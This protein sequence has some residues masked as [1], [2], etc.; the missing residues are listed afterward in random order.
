[1]I[2][3]YNTYRY[4]KKEWIRYF[5]QGAGFGAFI[6]YLFYSN[7]MGVFLLT[8]YGLI[9]LHV[10]KKKIIEKR[11]WRLNMEFRDGLASLSAALNAGYSIENAFG[12]AVEDLKLMYPADSMIVL[13]FERIVNELYMNQTV[14]AVLK[15]FADRSGLEDIADFA[16]VFETAKRTGGDIIKIIRTTGNTIN[17]KIEV[18]REIITLITGKKFEA[19]IM[20]LIP[21]FI[22]IYLRIFS[23]DFLKPLYHNLFG[24]LFMT[25]ILIIYFGVFQLTQK[26]ISIE[27]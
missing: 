19:D 11:K 6:G 26:I 24:T 3:D 2:N 12:Q 18:K 22:I 17:D 20:S 7:P 27:V 1:M 21:I 25:V 9:Y 10:K 4:S 14:E 16:E 5:L 13:E 15:D 23:G 8:S